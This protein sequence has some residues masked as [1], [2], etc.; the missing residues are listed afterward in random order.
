MKLGTVIHE[1]MHG[2]GFFHE[3]NRS[4]RDDY[5]YINW[6][7][8]RPGKMILLNSYKTANTFDQIHSNSFYIFLIEIGMQANFDKASSFSTSPFGVDYDYGS[9][10]HYSPNAFSRN[11]QPTITP[12][13]SSFQ[14]A[15]FLLLWENKLMTQSKLN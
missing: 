6:N 7:N 9:V 14:F 11:G 5:V 8:V 10:M 4:D 3:Q 13:V 12:K 15:H 2:L 1:M